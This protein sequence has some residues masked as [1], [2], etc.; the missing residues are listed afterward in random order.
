[1]DISSCIVSGA[2]NAARN[3]FIRGESTFVYMGKIFCF[4]EV[5]PGEYI[6]ESNG[7]YAGIRIID[8]GGGRVFVQCA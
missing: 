6:V 3:A 5:V 4:V 8:N 2:K 7:K 1:M